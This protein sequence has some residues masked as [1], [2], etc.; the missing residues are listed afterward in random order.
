MI[1]VELFLA[2]P[3]VLATCFWA[4]FQG[5]FEFKSDQYIQTLYRPGSEDP[6]FLKVERCIE[7]LNYVHVAEDRSCSG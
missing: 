1:L 6:H 3:S 7:Y 2:L 5:V 4:F